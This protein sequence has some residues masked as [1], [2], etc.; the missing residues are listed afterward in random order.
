MEILEQKWG[1]RDGPQWR[2]HNA[3]AVAVIEHIMGDAAPSERNA[4]IEMAAN[5]HFADGLSR[6][7]DG[8]LE[9]GF[10]SGD[11]MGGSM[12]LTWGRRRPRSTPCARRREKDP[13]HPIVN[14]VHPDHQRAF[15]EWIKLHASWRA[16]APGSRSRGCGSASDDPQDSARLPARAARRSGQTGRRSARDKGVRPA[17]TADYLPPWRNTAVAEDSPWPP[18]TLS[19]R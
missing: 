1:P 6:L 9:R 19:R 16:R 11:E 2:H 12:G 15:D 3:R 18:T 10:I 14:R 13:M 17:G 7:A 8:L 5:P 4:I